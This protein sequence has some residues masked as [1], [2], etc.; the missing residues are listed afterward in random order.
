MYLPVQR[1]NQSWRWARN[2]LGSFA[3][4]NARSWFPRMGKNVV[5]FG[6]DRANSHNLSSSVTTWP[7][8]A[9]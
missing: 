2:E 3:S 5:F 4:K 1:R 8:T 9:T 6:G 7:R